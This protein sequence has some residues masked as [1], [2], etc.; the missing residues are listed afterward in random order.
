MRRISIGIILVLV[1]AVTVE[2]KW[3][4]MT[5]T[6]TMNYDNFG[7]YKSGDVSKK[8]LGAYNKASACLQFLRISFKKEYEYCAEIK[9]V[10]DK[11]EPNSSW[12]KA[13]FPTSEYKVF[14][15]GALTSNSTT[16]YFCEEEQE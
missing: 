5:D 14:V 13:Q 11:G 8:A 10:S 3:I 7:K 6:K 4:A 2:A 16:Y 12:C 15:D 9:A 1:M